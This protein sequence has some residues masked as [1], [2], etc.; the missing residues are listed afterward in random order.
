MPTKFDQHA[1]TLIDP[2]VS[3]PIPAVAKLA[4]TPAAVPLLEP[5]VCL[6]KF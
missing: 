5:P 1:G 2:P 4:A 6:S 3:S